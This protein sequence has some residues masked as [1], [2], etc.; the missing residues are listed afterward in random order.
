[1]I[2]SPTTTITSASTA[3]QETVFLFGDPVSQ[4]LSPYFHT[5]V[6]RR[7]GLPWQFRVIESSRLQ[8]LEIVMKA[9]KFKGQAVTLPNKVVAMKL[10]DDLSNAAQIIGCVNTIYVR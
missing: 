5:T 2:Q 8:D 1:V 4:S 3:S 9:S 10:V 7:L 6:F